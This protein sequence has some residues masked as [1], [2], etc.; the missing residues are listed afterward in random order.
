MQHAIFQKWIK[1]ARYLNL[2]PQCQN[3]LNVDRYNLIYESWPHEFSVFLWLSL[4]CNVYIFFFCRSFIWGLYCMPQH[5]HSM[6][7]GLAFS[8]NIW[9]QHYQI[10]FTSMVNQR[11]LIECSKS[12][13]SVMCVPVLVILC[14]ITCS[15]RHWPMGGSTGHGLGVHSLYCSGEYNKNIYIL[16]TSNNPIQ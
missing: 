12:C 14:L 13:S 6:Q 16:C 3:F 15:D 2:F 4:F 11:L 10:I 7:V 8:L 9:P 5:W 1:I